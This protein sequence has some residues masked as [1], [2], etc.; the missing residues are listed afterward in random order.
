MGPSVTRAVE[1]SERAGGITEAIVGVLQVAVG[2]FDADAD[3]IV[4]VPVGWARKTGR[5][6]KRDRSVGVGV[7]VD[8]AEGGYRGYISIVVRNT[9]VQPLV[10]ATELILS[11]RIISLHLA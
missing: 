3:A 11:F 9:F 8:G 6:A 7:W 1:V 2:I 10:M 5:W 4:V